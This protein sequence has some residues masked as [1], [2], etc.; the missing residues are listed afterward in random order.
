[1]DIWGGDGEETLAVVFT[2]SII[3]IRSSGSVMG[4]GRMEGSVEGGWLGE[5]EGGGTPCQVLPGVHGRQEQ[6][7]GG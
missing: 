2:C 7:Y 6:L 4:A 5:W 1:M 3:C